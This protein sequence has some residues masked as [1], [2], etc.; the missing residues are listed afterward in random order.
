MCTPCS[1]G[2]HKLR[3]LLRLLML[4][5]R[6]LL[7]FLPLLLPLPL[8]LLR[9]LLLLL[10]PLLL[11]PML[12]LLLPL[13]LQL[14]S[15]CGTGSWEWRCHCS[16]RSHRGYGTGSSC[17]TCHRGSM[18]LSCKVPWRSCRSRCVECW[19]AGVAASPRCCRPCNATLLR[20]LLAS[21]G[22]R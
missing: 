22:C 2:G 18:A 20:G 15:M 5:L 13:L 1:S 9:P 16:T 19:Q 17:S 8:L 21:V 10:L 14:R 4:P 6:L 7:L 11:L 12:L 3:R